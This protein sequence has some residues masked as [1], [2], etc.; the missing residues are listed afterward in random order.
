MLKFAQLDLEGAREELRGASKVPG[1]D[2]RLTLASVALLSSST[3]NVSSLLRKLQ[4]AKTQLISARRKDKDDDDDDERRRRRRR[5]SLASL[6]SVDRAR[7]WMLGSDWGWRH[8]GCGEED[9]RSWEDLQEKL[10]PVFEA[11]E[12][13]VD[14]KRLELELHDKLQQHMKD[15]DDD[16]KE[17]EEEEEEEEREEEEGLYMFEERFFPQEWNE[18]G[19]SSSSPVAEQIEA[20]ED[21]YEDKI[22]FRDRGEERI[23]VKFNESSSEL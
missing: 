4:A 14:R 11:L 19:A 9:V 16:E 5:R 15:D 6:S 17:E 18:T 1:R 12:E 13:E 20:L 21:E 22:N 3:S 10:M 2:G 8:V 23:L 7:W